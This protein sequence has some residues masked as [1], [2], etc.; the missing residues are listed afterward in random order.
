[1]V[2]EKRHIF[3]V[4][5]NEYR[6]L[7]FFLFFI[8]V[9][10]VGF[11]TD[12]RFADEVH[13]YKLAE[14]W[15]KSGQRP[16]Y[17]NKVDE[18]EELGYRVPYSTG[19]LWQWGM[20]LLWK[21]WGRSERWLIQLYQ[22]TL[23][24][25]LVLS[26]YFLAKELYGRKTAY[27]A[28]LIGATLPLFIA[29]GILL[30]EEVPIAMLTTL[31]L[32]LIMRGKISLAGIVI[33]LMLL[34]KK[35]SYFL[36][37]A[38]SLLIFGSRKLE[39]RFS[40][41]KLRNVF[42]FLLLAGL[43]TLPDFLWRYQHFG[44]VFVKGDKGNVI[45]LVGGMVK[46]SI[47]TPGI[48]KQK[49]EP[50]S[51]PGIMKPELPKPV[52]PYVPKIKTYMPEILNN[53]INVVKYYGLP[54]LSLLLFYLF[55][56]NKKN[57]RSGFPLLL[58]VIS[59]LPF[60]FIF[61]SPWL[62]ARYI[63]PIL[64]FAAILAGKSF[65][66]VKEKKIR[67]LILVI[68]FL[69]FFAVLLFVNMQRKITSEDM[70]TFEFIRKQIPVEAKILTPEAHLILYHTGRPTLWCAGI[71]SKAGEL[72]DFFWGDS[73]L[74]QKFLSELKLKY[75]LILRERIYDDLKTRHYG[76]FPKSF[77]ETINSDRHFSLIFKNKKW[78]LW[79]ARLASEKS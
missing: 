67:S 77:Y 68:C 16:Q 62:G 34:T 31:C 8:L 36:I 74:R 52:E 2:E 20:V 21:L 22:A 12:L 45:G 11:A 49:L 6:F 35:N 29:L 23:Y 61:F 44:W 55:K 79:E 7:T 64:P 17:V 27:Y 73:S 28:G 71:P 78:E 43:I 14:E 10:L 13:H 57:L 38:F 53:P 76:G 33:G 9:L 1:M 65:E 39:F 56:L 54:L 25:L 72:Q 69:Q 4:I 63:A 47:L 60:F 32:L 51:T 48:T 40:F 24:F 26:I 42:L 41:V 66:L 19:P 46:K 3:I 30:F 37:P 75:L 5:R 70:A 59:Y 18:I 50:S 58:A 15:F